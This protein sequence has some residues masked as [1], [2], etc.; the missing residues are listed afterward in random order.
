MNTFGDRRNSIAEQQWNIASEPQSN[1]ISF[2]MV[3]QVVTAAV[4]LPPHVHPHAGDRHTYR[5]A[6]ARIRNAIEERERE[7]LVAVIAQ[8]NPS[9]APTRIG[10]RPK[11]N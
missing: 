8:A 3:A 6:A 2:H 5:R 4:K 9:A 7:H 1:R 10:N 11:K